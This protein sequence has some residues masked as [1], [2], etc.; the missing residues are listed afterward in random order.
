[1]E[2]ASLSRRWASAATYSSRSTVISI[3]WD[4]AS[5][6]SRVIIHVSVEFPC[7]L[8]VSAFAWQV[9]DLRHVVA[10]DFRDLR[11]LILI[12]LDGWYFRMLAESSMNRIQWSCIACRRISD[13]PSFARS[14]GCFWVWRPTVFDANL[15]GFI[16]L[17]G[18]L[19]SL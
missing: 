8:S 4:N 17:D 16:Q 13:A 3:T 19:K 18:R 1:M 9:V 7:A 12:A 14:F 10:H 2:C 6:Y 5:T 11:F 15:I